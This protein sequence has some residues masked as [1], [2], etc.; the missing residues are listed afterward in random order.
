MTPSPLA[1][2]QAMSG[3]WDSIDARFD[4]QMNDFE[5][6]CQS[7]IGTG[8]GWNGPDSYCGCCGGSGINRERRAGLDSSPRGTP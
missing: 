8:I 4:E 1:G 2:L 3:T 5:A 6:H 7:C